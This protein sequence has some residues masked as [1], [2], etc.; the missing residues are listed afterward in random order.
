MRRLTHRVRQGGFTLV[1]L[2]VA[3]LVA[4]IVLAAVSTLAGAAGAAWARGLPQEL[5]KPES[6]GLSVPQ[7]LHLGIVPFPFGVCAAD[8]SSPTHA[9]LECTY[10]ICWYANINRAVR[11]QSGWKKAVVTFPGA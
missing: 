1:E 8:L 2:M 7:W 3:L 5:Q 6:S 9:R 10:I 11:G 4:S